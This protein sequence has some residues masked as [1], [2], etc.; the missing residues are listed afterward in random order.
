M[1]FSEILTSLKGFS[2]KF[3]VEK[4]QMVENQIKSKGDH[5]K[6]QSELAKQYGM[7]MIK[8]LNSEAIENKIS[9]ETFKNLTKRTEIIKD[10]KKSHSFKLKFDSEIQQN[11]TR[12]D[13]CASTKTAQKNAFNISSQNIYPRNKSNDKSK[14]ITTLKNIVSNKT[15]LLFYFKFILYLN[16]R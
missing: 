7:K 5:K 2:D 9:F 8:N 6:I 10:S 14:P 16:L 13:S 3:L 12:V 15:M 11:N 1:K 4:M